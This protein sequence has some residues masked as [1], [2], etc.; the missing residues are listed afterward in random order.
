MRGGPYLDHP[1]RIANTK[2]LLL[3]G[4]YN[5]IFHPVGTL[6]TLRWLR[7]HNRGGHYERLVL[8]EYA[9]LDAIIGARAATDVYP[10]IAAFLDRT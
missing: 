8:P 10:R 3:Q 1:E 5:Y 4:R 2:L 6:R 7:A 9:H